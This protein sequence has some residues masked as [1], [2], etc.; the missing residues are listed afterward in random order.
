MK[1]VINP[2]YSRVFFHVG[3]L[4]KVTKDVYDET[5]GGRRYCVARVGDW[6]RITGMGL[7]TRGKKEASWYEKVYVCFYG[8]SKEYPW[9]ETDM[10]SIQIRCDHLESTGFPPGFRR[11]IKPWEKRDKERI[12]YLQSI[13]H[14][15]WPNVAT[16]M[17]NLYLRQEQGFLSGAAALRRKDGN[18]NH[19]K[20][21]SHVGFIKQ[22]RD[23]KLD[24][25]VEEL[26]WDEKRI[27]WDMIREDIVKELRTDYAN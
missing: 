20:F 21:M 17:M 13:I 5:M 16:W 12:D 27:Y 8:F 15:G 1:L 10:T 18:I 2:D 24:D 3:D 23:I 22:T 25:W 14:E 11:G 9:W 26:P 4:V 19:R 7:Y 6:G